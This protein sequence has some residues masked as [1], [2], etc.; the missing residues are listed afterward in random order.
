MAR[1]TEHNPDTEPLDRETD[2]QRQAAVERLASHLYFTMER[3]DPSDGRSW[4]ELTNA[5]R[6]FHRSLV[7]EILWELPREQWLLQELSRV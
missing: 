2:P 6:E 3:F 1:P 5:E 7:R 4:G